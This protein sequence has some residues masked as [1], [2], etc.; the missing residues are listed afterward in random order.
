MKNYTVAA[1]YKFTPFPDYE[2]WQDTIRNKCNEHE[3]CG[4]LLIASEGI[5]GT[6]AGPEAGIS[7]VLDWLSAIPGIGEIEVKYSYAVRKPFRRMKVRLKEEI[8]R[9]GVPGIDP[10]RTVG[11]YVDPEEWNKTDL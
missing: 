1:L 9:M 3:V 7:A 4:S 2:K 5:N 11:T 10:N 8:V 6:V